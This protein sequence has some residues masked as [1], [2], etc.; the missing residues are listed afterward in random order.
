MTQA[1]PRPSWDEIWMRMA[2]V[3]SE[4]SVDPRTKVGCVIVTYDNTQVL[5]VGYNGDER[6]G[7]NTPDS[8]EPG[9]SNLIHGEINALIKCDFSVH[10]KKRMYV[11]VSPC[12][13]CARAIVNAGVSELVYD[14]EYRDG[15]GLD[16]LK[17]A[18]VIVSKYV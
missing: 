14:F 1:L 13:V 4:R 8:D 10:K 9:Q 6:G 12:R 16:I 15:S 17:S 2:H 18:G 3:I 5:A 11:T 7:P